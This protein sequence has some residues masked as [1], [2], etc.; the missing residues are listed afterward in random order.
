MEDFSVLSGWLGRL[1]KVNI[2]I[3]GL[4]KNSEHYSYFFSSNYVSLTHFFG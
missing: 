1:R 4:N 2:Y 3:Y